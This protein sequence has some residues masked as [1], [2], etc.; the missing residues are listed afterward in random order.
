MPLDTELTGEVLDIDTE[1]TAITKFDTGETK[2]ITLTL[3]DIVEDIDLLGFPVANPDPRRVE[4]PFLWILWQLE[5][6]PPYFRMAEPAPEIPQRKFFESIKHYETVSLKH[7][8]EELQE[9]LIRQNEDKQK[10]YC[11]E[12]R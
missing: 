4:E 10:H 7:Y 6:V 11:R 12:R 8:E 2:E 5:Q 3:K 1:L 9:W